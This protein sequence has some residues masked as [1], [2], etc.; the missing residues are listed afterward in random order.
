MGMNMSIRLQRE[1]HRGTQGEE[2]VQQC[3]E[4]GMS[5]DN[6][7]STSEP[8]MGGGKAGGRG[9]G[10]NPV[11]AQN[12]KTPIVWENIDYIIIE[13]NINFL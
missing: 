2:W 11:W 5:D 9:G 13:Y 6:F 1:D 7:D 3:A 4:G 8:K 10:E 12:P